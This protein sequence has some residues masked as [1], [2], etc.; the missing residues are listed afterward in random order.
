MHPLFNDIVTKIKQQINEV[1]EKAK[2]QNI[3]DQKTIQRLYMDTFPD[4]VKA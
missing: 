4:V 3:N 1:E 2:Q